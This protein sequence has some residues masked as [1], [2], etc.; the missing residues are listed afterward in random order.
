MSNPLNPTQVASDRA[1]R[2]LNR[3]AALASTT[4]SNEV[5]EDVQSP[6]TAMEGEQSEEGN[7]QPT[8]TPSQQ[9]ENSSA[10]S[11]KDSDAEESD[12]DRREQGTRENPL[13]I[14]R[15]EKKV[16]GAEEQWMEM[17]KRL[18]ETITSQN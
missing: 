11:H 15:Q 17:M 9:D 13:H 8:P 18:V 4:T 14:G 6:L 12:Q 16:E 2:L 1:A 5:Q 7:E 10:H 3:G